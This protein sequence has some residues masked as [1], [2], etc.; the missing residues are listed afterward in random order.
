MSYDSYSGSVLVQYDGRAFSPIDSIKAHLINF[1]SGTAE[2]VYLQSGAGGATIKFVG[3]F[4]TKENIQLPTCVVTVVSET[5]QYYYGAMLFNIPT[6]SGS[7]GTTVYG[8]TC[9][10]V[11]RFD[12]WGHNGWER[13]VVA[14][15]VEN[16]LEWGNTPESNALYNVG[17]RD[18]RVVRSE[19]LGFDQTD[20]IIKEVDHK[21]M[22][23]EEYRRAIWTTIVA[24]VYFK[25][26][27]GMK[28][29]TTWVEDIVQRTYISSGTEASYDVLNTSGSIS[30]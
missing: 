7:S 24:D 1:L 3:D 6:S 30:N 8:K 2:T 18:L 20:R 4:P 19:I 27:T 12:V 10:Y 13:D 22:V 14:G 5:N 11:V 23:S 17:I 26:P 21:A 29:Y 16:W 15:Q 25:P 28:D 9:E